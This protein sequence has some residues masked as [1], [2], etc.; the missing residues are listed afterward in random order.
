MSKPKSSRIYIRQNETVYDFLW[1]GV[2]EDDSVYFGLTGSGKQNVEEIIISDDQK[3]TY[4]YSKFHSYSGSH[5]ISFHNSGWYV[6]Q[7]I[8]EDKREENRLVLKGTPINK[9]GSPIRMMDIILPVNQLTPTKKSVA[10]VNIDLHADLETHSHIGCTLYCMNN[11]KFSNFSE[12]YTSIIRGASWESINAFV[13]NDNTWAFVLH[14]AIHDST[15]KNY[16][17]I[18]IFGEVS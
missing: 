12:N 4:E 2:G 17:L 10:D 18:K 15:K 3:N 5:K 16:S 11:S 9:I 6:L 14:D 7:N 1:G 13:S 8:V